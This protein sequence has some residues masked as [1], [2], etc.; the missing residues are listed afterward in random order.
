IDIGIVVQSLLNN[1]LTNDT[2]DNGY[3]LGI[4]IYIRLG[5]RGRVLFGKRAIVYKGSAN[6]EIIL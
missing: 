3:I 2:L 6:L 1:A 4:L 5:G